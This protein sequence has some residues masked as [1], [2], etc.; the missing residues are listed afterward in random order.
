MKNDVLERGRSSF[1]RILQFTFTSDTNWGALPLLLLPPS[2]P[3]PRQGPVVLHPPP[4]VASSHRGGGP[5]QPPSSGRA[6][7]QPAAMSGWARAEKTCPRPCVSS[8]N[9]IYVIPST[10]IHDFWEKSPGKLSCLSTRRHKWWGESW[11]NLPMAVC[12]ISKT[13]YT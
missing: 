10:N 13:T 7:C 12:F 4:W 6:T 5:S 11:K 2:P 1:E 3:P 8:V 9:H